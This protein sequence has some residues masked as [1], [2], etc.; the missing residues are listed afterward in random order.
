[1][2]ANVVA[3]RHPWRG[4]MRQPH[5]QSM[6]SQP[7]TITVIWKIFVGGQIHEKLSHEIRDEIILTRIIS[8]KW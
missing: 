4:L 8:Y 7:V 3:R 6:Y 2:N 5:N 1:M